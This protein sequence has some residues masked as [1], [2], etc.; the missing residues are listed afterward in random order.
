MTRN[1]SS[2]SAEAFAKEG[3]EVVKGDLDHKES[4]K[5]AFT[6]ANAIFAVTDFW[7]HF[8]NPDNGPKAEAAG[9]T[10][11]EYAMDL[12]IAQGMNIAEV[13]ASPE[14]MKT[15]ERFV[16]SSLSEVRKWSKGKYTNVYHFDGKATIVNNV[17]SQL[18]ELAARMSTVLIGHYVTNWKVFDVMAPRKKPDGSWVTQKPEGAESKIP[19]V[20]T[21]RD[22]GAFVKA[23]I[24]DLPPGKQ[25][26][27]V[28]EAMTWPEWMRIWGEHQGVKAGFEQVSM[29]AFLSDVPDVLKKELAESYQFNAEFGWDG[30]DPD[31]L[32]IED[33]SIHMISN[34]GTRAD[35]KLA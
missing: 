5:A 35:M 4:L 6:G 19:F 33:V 13:A 30:G 16:F 21:E 28:S 12:E 27:G 9:R 32:K 29:E 3:V 24:L 10:I 34:P 22:T 1:P 8:R 20:C 15:L 25:L 26:L 17:K 18:P 14:V 2:S 23:L 31:V 11:N 7:T